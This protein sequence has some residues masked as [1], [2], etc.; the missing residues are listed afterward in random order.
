MNGHHV[1]SQ[2]GFL[3]IELL[4]AFGVM[5][6]VF[7][8]AFFYISRLTKEFKAACLEIELREAAN[9]VKAF[10]DVSGNVSS[11]DEPEICIRTDA[12]GK[13]SIY[14]LS[15]AEESLLSDADFIAKRCDTPL[16]RFFPKDECQTLYSP[17]GGM[18]TISSK[19]LKN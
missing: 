4:V 8:L 14:P 2:R 13:L 18:W 6:F 15:G 11:W 3:L 9:N 12:E 10:L 1:D 7:P 19:N 16:I 17:N 5:V